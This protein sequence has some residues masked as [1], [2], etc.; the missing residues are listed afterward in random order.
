MILFKAAQQVQSLAMQILDKNPD[1][2]SNNAKESLKE[3]QKAIIV[4]SEE[5]KSTAES[6]N[7]ENKKQEEEEEEEDL[8]LASLFG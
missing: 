3:K 4:T 2:L 1:A 8:G 6:N 7:G 5:S